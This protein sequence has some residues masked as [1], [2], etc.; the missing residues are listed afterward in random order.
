MANEDASPSSSSGPPPDQGAQPDSAPAD[1]PPPET[2]TYQADNAQQDAPPPEDDTYQADNAQQ[3]APPPE[4][5]TY[6]AGSG[7]AG[8]PPTETDTYQAD[9]A[10]QDA[11]PAEDDTT[12]NYGGAA[13]AGTATSGVGMAASMV[14]AYI[15]SLDPSLPFPPII[16]PFNPG[17]YTIKTAGKW[18][19]ALQPATQG[20]PPQWQGVEPR[21]VSVEMQLDSF[22]VPPIP[23]SVVIAQLKMMVLPTAL[24]VGMGNAMAPFVTFGWG[25]NVILDMAYIES[26]SVKY[27]RFL[28]GVPVRA[29]ATLM[30]KEVPLPFPLGATNPTSGGLATRRTRTVVA[31][32]TLASIAHQEYDDPNKWR[33]VAEAN[34]IDD[35]MRIK[36]GMVLTV[37][38]RREAENMS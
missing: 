18:S 25:P 7:D 2:D 36:P 3:D 4:D 27:E 20:P 11:P 9:N 8:P 13:V 28:L 38:D 23:P 33:A 22:S 10:Q 19:S 6:Q 35:P 31:G 15:Q 34:K 29:L 14:P 12:P 16:F 30:L 32:D 17:S 21:S 24:S 26:V 5:D 1:A 37:P